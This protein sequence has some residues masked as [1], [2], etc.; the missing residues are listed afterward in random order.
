MSDLYEAQRQY[1]ISRG[2]VDETDNLPLGI[3]PSIF[4]YELTSTAD[5]DDLN[6]S[7]HLVDLDDFNA[8]LAVD[9]HSLDYE[10]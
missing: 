9:Y 5:L 10:F 6:D 4:R 3:F 1:N 8:E 2:I 7:E